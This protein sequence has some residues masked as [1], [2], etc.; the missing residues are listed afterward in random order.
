[1]SRE[2]QSDLA[3]FVELKCGALP[4]K[5]LGVLL[6]CKKLSSADCQPLLDK[7]TARITSW[8]FRYISHAGRFQLIDSFCQAYIGTGALYFFYQSIL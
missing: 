7:I 8:T 2:L 6:T 1:M 5:Y 3:K 4:V